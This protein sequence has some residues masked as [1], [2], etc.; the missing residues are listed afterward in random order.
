ML[1][2]E[3]RARRVIARLAEERAALRDGDYALL[4]KVQKRR[5]A[6][7]RALEAAPPPEADPNGLL[8]RLKEEAQRTADMAAAYRQGVEE[9]RAWLRDIRRAGTELGAYTAGGA[10]VAMN[11]G[12]A[13]KD[14]RA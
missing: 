1:G 11:A 6:A 7:L 13:A 4:A 14:E 5:D 3:S 12:P 10:R 2:W 9:A 8:T